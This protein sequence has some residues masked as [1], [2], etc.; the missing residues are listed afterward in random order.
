MKLVCVLDADDRSN[1]AHIKLEAY[2]Y[3]ITDATK[4]ITLD[5]SYVKVWQEADKV[6]RRLPNHLP[7]ILS[8][9]DCQRCDFEDI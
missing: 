8:T 2:G 7:G 9:G 5:G 1:K 3:A 4:A 6:L